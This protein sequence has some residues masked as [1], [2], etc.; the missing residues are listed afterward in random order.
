MTKVNVH[1]G[2]PDP[3]YDLELNTQSQAA[4]DIYAACGHSDVNCPEWSAFLEEFHR[5][6]RPLMGSRGHIEEVYEEPGYDL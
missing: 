4:Y 5:Q 6:A 3:V 1:F 2:T